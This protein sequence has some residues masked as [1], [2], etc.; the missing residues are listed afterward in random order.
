MNE[1]PIVQYKGLYYISLKIKNLFQIKDHC[2]FIMKR[3]L[4]PLWNAAN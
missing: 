1:S 4:Q 2:D 3:E